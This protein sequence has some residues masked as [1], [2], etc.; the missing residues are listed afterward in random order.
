[1][2]DYSKFYFNGFEEVQLD[3]NEINIQ[4][5]KQL[6]EIDQAKNLKEKFFWESKYQNTLDLRPNVYNY[7]NV[8]VEFIK[9][10]GLLEKVRNISQRDLVPYHVQI[11]KSNPGPSYMDWHRDVYTT[12]SGKTS[13]MAPS[14]IKIIVYPKCNRK[15][16]P[17]LEILKGSHICHLKHQGYDLSLINSGILDK[18]TIMSNNNSCLIFDIA[19]LHRVV[20]D[21]NDSS[22]RLIYS[23]I[24]RQQFEMNNKEKSIHTSYKD[25]FN[26]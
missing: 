9:H 10:N 25:L 7:D 2:E 26:V 6:E 5:I 12:E 1:M 24:A 16:E 11:R 8:F 14:G 18:I 17:R 19:S 23:F 3:S 4:L 21:T 15:S 22:I 13:G 20:P